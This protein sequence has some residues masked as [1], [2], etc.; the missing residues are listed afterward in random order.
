MR[1]RSIKPE[2]W[3]SD[4]IAALGYFDRLLF[5]ALWSYVDDNGVGRDEEGLIIGDCFPMDMSRDPRDTLA[6]IADGL[7]RLADACLIER[8][9]VE[10]RK[11]LHVK[12]WD[13][14]QRIDRP[15]KPRYPLPTSTNA[16]PREDSARPSRHPREGSA[17]GTGEQGN[18]GTDLSPHHADADALIETPQ[19]AVAST[20][21]KPSSNYPQEFERFW[22]AYPLK[23]DKGHALTAWRKATRQASNDDIIAGAIRYRDDPTRKPDMTKY[24]EGWLNGQ[25]WLDEYQ[26]PAQ[27][28]EE[29]MQ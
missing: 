27:P 5:I 15:N 1:I 11:Y 8:Y 29:W 22:S 23:K 28:A 4:D 3:R 24:A 10:N 26:Q 14:H 16:H 17:T 12:T 19:P 6:R 21:K 7:R 13:Q 9:T 2:F 25:R 18:R 20:A